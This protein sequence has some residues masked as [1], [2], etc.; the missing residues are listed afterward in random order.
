MSKAAVLTSVTV[1]IENCASNSRDTEACCTD[2]LDAGG[3][4][5]L[6][7]LVITPPDGGLMNHVLP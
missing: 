6:Y 5:Q 4:Q 3:G 1:A 2:A 7:P